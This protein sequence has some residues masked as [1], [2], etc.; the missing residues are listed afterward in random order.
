[1]SEKDLELKFTENPQMSLVIQTLV[2]TL[3]DELVKG[4]FSAIIVIGDT[5]AD[6]TYKGMVVDTVTDPNEPITP[7]FALM[8]AMAHPGEDTEFFRA[9]VYSAVLSYLYNQP[10]EIP[11]FH[12]NFMQMMKDARKRLQDMLSEEEDDEPIVENPHADC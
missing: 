6:R 8:N 5:K 7:D 1:M 10:E 3:L 9:M 4:G 2:R 12:K 11:E